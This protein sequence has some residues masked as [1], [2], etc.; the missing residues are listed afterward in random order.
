M[1][2][3]ILG[4][5]FTG[6]TTIFNALT[7]LSAP[8]GRYSDGP[9]ESNLGM[10]A[11]PDERVERLAELYQSKKK[12]YE[13]IEFHDV[14]GLKKG[15]GQDSGLSASLLGQLR[16]MDA[17][18]IVVRVFDRE[19]VPHPDGRID[20]VA[21][22]EMMLGELMLA[23]LAIAEKRVQKLEELLG[24]GVQEDRDKRIHEKDVLER[25]VKALNDSIPIR[26]LDFKGE[27]LIA[28]RSY[29]F[30]T[31]KPALVL[32]NVGDLTE[33]EQ[34]KR[35]EALKKAA[36]E[37]KVGCAAIN[38]DIECEL[39]EITDPEEQQEYMEAMGIEERAASTVIRA[40]Y[41]ITN[42]MTFLTAG[43]KESRA[44]QVREGSSAV[45][46]ADRIHSDIAR[47]FIRA[48]VVPYEH[49][50]ADGSIAKAR[51][52]GHYREEGKDAII[53][54]GDVIYFRFNV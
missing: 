42:S 44:W 21:D 49:L 23:D 11:V 3:G 1:Q 50:I 51:E 8:T 30:L 17:L 48:E 25:V 7:G 6:K 2:I 32:A 40:A 28:L 14:G 9:G 27:E 15:A 53:H 33:D 22:L 39:R 19:S 52:A 43:E 35:V 54:D 45:Q 36:G 10:V 13:T 29:G 12:T 38:G 46:A 24:K 34:I 4:L 16:D 37:Y 20:P 41:D 47:G 26:D 31:Q 5:P 18:A